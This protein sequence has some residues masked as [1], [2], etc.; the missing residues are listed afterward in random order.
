[1]I[2]YVA[3]G[4]EIS[5]CGRYRYLLWREWRGTHNPKHWEWWHEED[6]SGQKIGIPK[7]V[8]FVM[9]NPSIADGEKD[10]PTIRR[11]VSFARAWNYERLEVVN[12]FAYRATKPKDLFAAGDDMHG[13]DNQEVIEHAVRDAGIVICAWGAHDIG[14]QGEI[15][16]GWMHMKRHYALGFTKSG[17]PRHPLY[18]KLD[19]KPIRM[20][21]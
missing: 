2:D 17:A 8:L 12:L 11:C 14:E 9:L 1:M 21:D 20:L 3:K 10:D 16:R 5:A 4:A 18:M 13:P 6:G 19:S 15:V 7:S